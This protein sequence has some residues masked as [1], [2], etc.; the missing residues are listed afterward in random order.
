M[1]LVL[2]A[3]G[4]VAGAISLAG[5]CGNGAVGTDA[6]RRIETVRCDRAEACGIDLT[7]SGAVPTPRDACVRYYRDACLH[8]L[9]TTEEPAP[10]AVDACV[11]ALGAAAC[12]SIERPALEP[13]CAW[14]VPPG[15]GGPP[16]LNDGAVEASTAPLSADVIVAESR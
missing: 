3:V 2:L 15:D 7:R 12:A 10:E 1:R 5:A 14:L 4:M 9:V 11:A 8:G 16:A 6:C 13:A